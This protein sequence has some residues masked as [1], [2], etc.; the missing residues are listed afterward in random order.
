M[1]AFETRTAQSALAIG[2]CLL[3]G[4]SWFVLKTPL[5]A[6][7]LGLLP[8]AGLFVL[9]FPVVV[10]IAFIVFS[11]FRIHEAYPQL[12]PFRLPQLLALG[13]FATLG[14]QLMTRRAEVFLTVELK[15]LLGFFGL[16][17]LGV[18]AATNFGL[19]FKFWNGTFVKVVI[20]TFAIAWLVRRPN[21]LAVA[22][23]V[24]VIAGILVALVAIQNRLNEIGLVEGTRVTIGRSFGSMLGDPNDLALVLLFPTGFA[25]AMIVGRGLGAG[26]RMLGTIAI[27]TIFF[28][29]LFTQ[30]R[31]GLLGLVAVL[32]VFAWNRSRN[33]L[34]LIVLGLIGGAALFAVA[35]IGDR[36]VVAAA[37]GM[38]ESAA[39]RLHAWEAAFGMA[40]AHPL[41][42]VGLDNYYVNYY[43]YSSFWDGKNHAVHSTWFGVMAESGFLGFIVFLTMVIATIRRSLKSTAAAFAFARPVARKDAWIG[44]SREALLAAIA[45]FCVSGTFLTQG[46]IWP[47]YILMAL[48]VAADRI[49]PAAGET[50]PTAA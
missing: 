38:D 36:S 15:L 50:P 32:G 33:K 19:A 35:G 29:I 47:F 16:V 34:L 6:V 37:E 49:Q 22:G 7:V 46:F 30:S 44:V 42:G 1:T 3:A 45:G 21:D 9:R 23:R 40:L 12:G 39:G 28:G 10:V 13:A 24:F 48:V 27:V 8:F 41:T 20:M 2:I 31:G 4:A 43:L 14:Y 17:S 11:L 25:C 18:V 26:D 5:F